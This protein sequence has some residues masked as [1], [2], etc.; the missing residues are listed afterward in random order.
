MIP[1]SLKLH[2]FTS[3]SEDT[4]ALDFSSFHLAVLSGRN[5]AG[6][7]SLLDAITWCVW[8]TSRAGDSSDSLVK[9]GS[10]EMKVEFSFD[11]DG[12]LFKVLRSRTLKGGGLTRL[13]FYGGE[14]NLTEGTIKSTQEKIINTLHLTYE[15]FTNSSFL[16]QGNADE[17]TVKGAT[18]RKRILAEILN[19]SKYDFLEEKA[20]ESAK[21][22]GMNV[23]AINYS[24][25]EIDNELG[26]KEERQVTLSQIESELKIIE[27][28]E[29]EA[30]A[31]LK[32]IQAQGELL[33]T[34]VSTLEKAQERIASLK[35]EIESLKNQK[36]S[37]EISVKDFQTILAQEEIIEK[38]ASLL[39]ELKTK[40]K[41]WQIKQV[42]LN[43]LQQ[44]LL[45]L[46]TEEGDHKSNLAVIESQLLEIKERGEKLTKE[47][48]T[49]GKNN[50]LCPTCGQK[51]EKDSQAHLQKE[52]GDKIAQER[53]NYKNT[54]VEKT[55]A[56]K[57]LNRVLVQIP[58]L[59]E[60]INLFKKE[61]SEYEEIQKKIE[62]LGENDVLKIKLSEAKGKIE[63]ESK[64]LKDLEAL[65]VARGKTIEKESE[66]LKDYDL[67]KSQL[68]DLRND[69]QKKENILQQIRSQKSEK[70]SERGAAKE[71]V[72][73][74]TQLET[75]KQTKI[76]ERDR[77][78][79]EK[80]D[81]EELSLA[82]GKK[83]IQAMIIENA[84]PE[85]E[86]EANALLD[87]LTDGRMRVEFVTQKEAKSG[88]T[89][90]TLDIVI[91]DESGSRPY[92]LYSGG[93][94]FRVNFA[95]RLALSKLLTHRA[96]A[97]LQFLVIDEGFGTQDT[98]GR[99]RMI[100]AINAIK[101]DYAK[102]LVVTHVEEL[103]EAFPNQIVVTKNTTGSSFEVVG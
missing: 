23:E 91:S 16:R 67:Y 96:G 11:L 18:D 81:Y 88:T 101:N 58:P 39:E 29:K 43:S 14:K 3:Y 73:R 80:Q 37:K 97:K 19:L 83:G 65:L 85:I 45:A 34:K 33:R 84:I 60:K 31:K 87:K 30:E 35:E 59:Q 17:F 46:T 12:Q 22:L 51:L 82:F 70:T 66:D 40:A 78:S 21:A 50:A 10:K 7:S 102:V 20:K 75:L 41:E 56:K 63:T 27:A 28:Q 25:V 71:L 74:S 48:A 94:A 38:N 32:E 36:A 1:V 93:E 54:L 95:I 68:L 99:D 44:E 42:E 53:N 76:K 100:E 92:E 57:K 6:K 24:L 55:E 9:Q 5:G 47:L 98:E 2:N 64:G 86:A 15:T 62:E 52:F 13:D 61:F 8:G 26:E 90:E 77:L 103:K 72:T 4:P 69:Y 49:T 79:L 89:I